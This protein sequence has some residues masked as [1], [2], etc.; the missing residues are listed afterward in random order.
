MKFEALAFDS[1]AAIDLLRHD[2]QTPPAFAETRSLVMP[3]FVLAE[4][5]FGLSHAT[6]ASQLDELAAACRI[7]TPDEE[8]L[9]YY[10]NVREQMFRGRT[11]PQSAERR[12]GLHHDVWIAALC[13]QHALPLLTRDN[14]FVAIRDLVVI[15]WCEGP[16]PYPFAASSIRSTAMHTWF[17]PFFFA[18]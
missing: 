5:R 2:R 6:R 10:V 16:P 15:S 14:D 12:E 1:N 11:L 3:L 8:T 7:L 4:L 13:L 18:K 9:P 17:L